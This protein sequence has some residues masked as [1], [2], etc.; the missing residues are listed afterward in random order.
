MTVQVLGLLLHNIGL[1]DVPI[2]NY[3]VGTLFDIYNDF[4]SRWHII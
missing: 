4:N 2:T 3:P 1:R